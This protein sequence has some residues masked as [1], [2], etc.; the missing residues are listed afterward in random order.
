MW[1]EENRKLFFEC[2]NNLHLEYPVR[3]MQAYPQHSGGVSFAEPV[4][5][6]FV[7]LVFSAAVGYQNVCLP[8][9]FLGKCFGCAGKRCAA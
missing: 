1:R 5:C 3:T 2:L 7:Y 6:V 9:G 8:D 4:D